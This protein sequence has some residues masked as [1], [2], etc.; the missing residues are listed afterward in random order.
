MLD[1]EDMAL[2]NLTETVKCL[3]GLAAAEERAERKRGHLVASIALKPKM[4][5]GR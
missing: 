5:R 1:E 4:A 3:L 2:N